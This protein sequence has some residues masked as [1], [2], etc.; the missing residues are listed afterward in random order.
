MHKM[1]RRYLRIRP[2]TPSDPIITEEAPNPPPRAD[3]TIDPEE[4][5]NPQ[6]RA[7]DTFDEEDVTYDYQFQNLGSSGLK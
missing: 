4:V 6:P 1:Y 7:D 5:P 2:S 3:G